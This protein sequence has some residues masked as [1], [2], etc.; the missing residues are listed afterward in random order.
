MTTAKI[1]FIDEA[2]GKYGP[3][4]KIKAAP[5]AGG[6]DIICY[7]SQNSPVAK[8][9]AKD[10]ILELDTTAKF[11]KIIGIAKAEE[12]ASHSADFAADCADFAA[13]F[14]TICATW[15]A[16]YDFIHSQIPAASDEAKLSAVSTVFIQAAREKAWVNE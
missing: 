7:I 15:T 13:D 11:P 1:K 4:Y 9:L 14:A 2:A 8:S 3:Q 6:D 5:T 10:V 16:A 12:K